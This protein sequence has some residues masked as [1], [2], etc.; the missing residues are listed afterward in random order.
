MES[1]TLPMMENTL[2]VSINYRVGP[3]G[4]LAL[5]IAG[6]E[7]NFGLQDIWLGLQWI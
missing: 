2:V 4:F 7:G 3:L 6:I 1:L 5:E